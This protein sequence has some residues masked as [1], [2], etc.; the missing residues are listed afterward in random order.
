[1]EK[2]DVAVLGATGIVGQ[3]FI[4]LLD[5]HPFLKVHE[6]VASEKSKGR[7]LGDVGKQ[8]LGR[9]EEE[10]LEMVVKGTE[11]K[12]E[13]EVVFSA[14]NSEDTKE[15]EWK[16]AREGKMVISKAG[17]NRMDRRVPLLI[18]EVNPDHLELLEKQKEYVRGGLVTDPNCTAMILSLSLKPLTDRFRIRRVMATSM[19][20]LSGAGY[21]GM[22]SLD[23]INNVVPH[24]HNEE[25]KLAE[26]PKKI[27]GSLARGEI[28]ESGMEIFGSCSRVPVINGHTISVYVDFEEEV[29]A[30]EARDAMREFKGLEKLPSAPRVPVIVRDEENRPQPRLDSDGMAVSVGRIRQ[31]LDRRSV[32]YFVVG[33]NLVRGAAGAG[34]LDAEL[35]RYQG[36]I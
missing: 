3:K 20:A 5:G 7:K 29:S 34:I 11:E 21:P 23:I 4:E 27:F 1:M 12:L 33:D 32:A 13:S 22:A 15:I 9:I 30:D 14:L 36:R 25:E 18:P 6:L 2:I 35:M 28:K 19:Q 24:I 31:G 10:Y 26:E 8:V 17:A 16:L